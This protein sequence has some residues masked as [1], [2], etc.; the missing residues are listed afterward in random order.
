V[1]GLTLLAAVLGG[2]VLGTAAGA[3]RMSSAHQRLLGLTNP[4][5]LLVSPP[6]DPTADPT[7]LSMTP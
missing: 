4:L 3:R 7:P 6:G 2:I 5:E 1:L